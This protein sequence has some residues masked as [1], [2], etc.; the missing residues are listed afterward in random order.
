MLQR[1]YTSKTHK[2]KE[3]RPKRENIVGFHLCETSRTDKSRDRK[4]IGSCQGLGGGGNGEQLL[5]GCGVLFG[6]NENV[7]ELEGG[8]SGTIS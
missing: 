5:N 7:L 3:A 4:Q 6:I 1:G 2:V 8:G